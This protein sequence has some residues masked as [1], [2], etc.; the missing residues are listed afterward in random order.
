M[1]AEVKE[2]GLVTESDEPDGG[3][4]V[5]KSLS[6]TETSFSL[7]QSQVSENEYLSVK[8]QRFKDK[9]PSLGERGNWT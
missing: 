2:V 7:S 5:R 9:M 6:G 3:G 8:L 1:Q 4:L